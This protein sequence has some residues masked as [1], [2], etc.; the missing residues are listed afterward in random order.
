MWTLRGK[1]PFLFCVYLSVWEQI[2]DLRL[3]FP[4]L[5]VSKSTVDAVL[6]REVQ[7]WTCFFP[8]QLASWRILAGS[9]GK[10]QGR[11]GG[12]GPSHHATSEFWLKRRILALTTLICKIQ[13][14]F[15]FLEEPRAWVSRKWSCSELLTQN[16]KLLSFSVVECT[17]SAAAKWYCDG[18][19]LHNSMMS[20]FWWE[21]GCWAMP[22]GRERPYTETCPTVLR[23]SYLWKYSIYFFMCWDPGFPNPWLARIFF[24]KSPW[25]SGQAV[26]FQLTS[27]LNIPQWDQNRAVKVREEFPSRVPAYCICSFLPLS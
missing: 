7:D 22:L 16:L 23:T 21:L 8:I 14:Y 9:V 3:M 27:F 19:G 20:A 5:T 24:Q 10:G 12:P 11:K 18:C 17:A 13:M 25:L 15:D 2:G 26:N 1:K 6:G 4:H